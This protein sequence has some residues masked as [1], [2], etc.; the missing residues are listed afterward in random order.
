MKLRADR[1]MRL[2]V[3]PAFTSTAANRPR[4]RTTKSTSAPALLRQ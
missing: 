1:G 3:G 4:C 2:P